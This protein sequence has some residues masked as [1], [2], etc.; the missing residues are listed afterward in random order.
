M[1]ALYKWAGLASLGG[2][3]V[4]AACTSILG[5]DFEV[6]PGGGDGG[7][8][9]GAMGGD[10]SGGNGGS[11]GGGATGGTGGGGSPVYGC[12]WDGST[13]RNV[14]TLSGPNPQWDDNINYAPGDKQIRL[15]LSRQATV[16]MYSIDETDHDV[17]TLTTSGAV[18]EAKRATVDRVGVLLL[19]HY[20]ASGQNQLK[21][22]VVD[23][24]DDTG[25][26]TVIRE[27]TDPISGFNSWNASFAAVGNGNASFI[28]DV[29]FYFS[30]QDQGGRRLVHQY[31]S[32]LA[33]FGNGVFDAA[34]TEDDYRVVS[35]AYTGGRSVVHLG[36]RFDGATVTRV[37]EVDDTYAGN[38]LSPVQTIPADPTNMSQQAHYFLGT[39][40][41]SS[42]DYL[43][44][45]AHV[46]TELVFHAG[47]AQASEVATFNFADT[48][49][50]ANVGP[51]TSIP[52]N[53]GLTS[54]NEGLIVGG[55]S[56]DATSVQL[57][58]LHRSDGL[59]FHESVPFPASF[60]P[61]PGSEV[62]NAAAVAENPMLFDQIGGKVQVAFILNQS[63]QHALYYGEI[64]CSAR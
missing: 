3:L 28:G 10:P 24:S 34:G 33:G 53:A 7:D 50:I 29:V 59:R 57:L 4:V 49:P 41:R 40:R 55:A 58:V 52:Q 35:V 21:F 37:F 45:F 2:T 22:A 8:G 42:S 11:G 64:I 23:D 61:P 39:S 20:L 38:M 54:T 25:M 56:N 30:Y 13:I 32:G 47:V 62:V 43:M 5:D 48:M 1:N 60:S 19:E 6:V 36:N 31:W 14:T 12:D 27:V 15:L 51:F 17:F 44:L 18:I 63:S 16:E 9:A 26:N 46:Q